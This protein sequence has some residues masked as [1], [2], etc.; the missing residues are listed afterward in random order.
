[1][2]VMN[3]LRIVED[4]GKCH[5]AIIG[6]AYYS[7]N[8]KNRAV[9]SAVIPVSHSGGTDWSIQLHYAF[10]SCPS[11]DGMA[12]SVASSI[13]IHLIADNGSVFFVGDNVP[14]AGSVY[15]LYGP[16][17]ERIAFRR[18]TNIH[19]HDAVFSPSGDLCCYATD[20]CQNPETDRLL[21]VLDCTSGEEVRRFS[22]AALF[23]GGLEPR[24]CYL[25]RSC[26]KFDV[27]GF[28]VIVDYEGKIQN[29][30]DFLAF[31]VER[32]LAAEY[33]YL[34]YDISKELPTPL[35]LHVLRLALLKKTDDV[36]VARIYRRMGE[37]TEEVG[38]LDDAVSFYRQ[39]LEADPKVGCK[40]QLASCEKRLKS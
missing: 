15:S 23:I 11:W 4:P 1:M 21:V 5:A 8:H 33:A 31:R 30:D 17:G 2:D 7:P 40:R 39:A 9:V 29:V 10:E 14:F 24:V 12:F 27:G 3:E 38:S 20:H 16:S 22:F 19:I 18:F 37:L 35:A 25:D 36:T 26:I 13:I 32:A 34:A 6:N 28:F